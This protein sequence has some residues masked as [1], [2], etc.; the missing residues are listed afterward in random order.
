MGMAK[1][2]DL[3]AITTKKRLKT[4]KYQD[5]TQYWGITKL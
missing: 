2:R 3:R 1:N 5:A 4:I